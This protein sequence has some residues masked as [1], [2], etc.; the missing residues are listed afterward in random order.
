MSEL[1]LSTPAHVW[2]YLNRVVEGP[3]HTLSA[4]LAQYPAEEI[5][6]GIYNAADWLGPLAALTA[7]RRDWLRQEVDLAAAERVG[8]RIISSDSPE[9]PLQQFSQAFGFY[10]SG[11]SSAPATFDDQA[12]SP[13]S[14]WV[15]GGNLAVELS[16]ALA[17]VGTRAISRYGWD[18]TRLIAGGLAARQWTIVSGGA[19]GVDTAAHSAAIEQGGRTVAVAACGIDRSYP[20]RN[21]GLFDKIAHNGCVVSE[22]APGTVPKRH[23]F[24]TRNRLV[25]AM[26][27]GVVVVEAGFRS[28]ALNT[29]N[30]AEA[31]GKV[32]MAVPGP[33]TTAG[34]LGAHLRIQEGRAQ[35]V[36]SA[37]EIRALV[38][39]AGS[40][41]PGAQY[42]L[43]YAPSPLQRLSRN[44]LRVF[45]ST[46]L[47]DADTAASAEE[48]A[49]EAR[50][51]VALTIHLLVTLEKAGL[52][53][54]A[55]TQWRRAGNY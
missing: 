22:F 5:A 21:Q 49:G 13:H 30:W 31:L 27:E 41:D 32:A 12:A 43:D 19:L 9:W 45:D 4:L 26:S 44:E 3:S 25:A 18:A 6:H 15:R 23:R 20:A 10:R 34:S 16:Q 55:G 33:V 51:S 35:L 37:D 24:L 50:L 47:E 28:G 38:G 1:N 14:L 11:Q 46:P 17:L 48:I 52:V 39:K 54:R 7:S 29:L 40:L 53:A 36:T 42:E 8:A 2:A